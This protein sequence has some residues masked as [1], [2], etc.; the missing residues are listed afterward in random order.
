MIAGKL[1]N[2]HFSAADSLVPQIEGSDRPARMRSPPRPLPSFEQDVLRDLRKIL[3]PAATM[4]RNH[5]LHWRRLE[6]SSLIPETAR[7]AGC[8]FP[9]AETPLSL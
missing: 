5:I 1:G 4:F 6:R 8:N 2:K 7:D 3:G 9:V